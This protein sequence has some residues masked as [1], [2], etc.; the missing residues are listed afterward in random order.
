MC[1]LAVMWRPFTHLQTLGAYYA[2]GTTPG[3]GYTVMGKTVNAQSLSRV[4][5]LVTPWTV[6]H[7]APLSMGF[8]RQGYWSG[9]PF[10]LP[11]DLPNSGIELASPVSSALQAG[12]LPLSRLGSPVFMEFMF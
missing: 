7:Q 2:L 3:S 4:Q 5:L 11:R 9:S 10:P 6:A 1:S 12:S 8:S